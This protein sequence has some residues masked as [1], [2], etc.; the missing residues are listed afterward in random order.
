[1]KRASVL[2]LGQILGDMMSMGGNKYI[3]GRDLIIK[4]IELLLNVSNV[5]Q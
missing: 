5:Q 4:D 3:L 2:C 1:M